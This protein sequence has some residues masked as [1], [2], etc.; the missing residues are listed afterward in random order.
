MVTKCK[1]EINISHA[2]SKVI[3]PCNAK[4]NEHEEGEKYAS[5][6]TRLLS[7]KVKKIRRDKEH[8]KI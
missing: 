6:H 4:Y 3:R 1:L 5:Q 2:V 8:T 7:G